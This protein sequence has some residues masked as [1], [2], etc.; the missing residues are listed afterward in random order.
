MTDARDA[1]GG[2]RTSENGRDASDCRERVIA[3]GV[4]LLLFGLISAFGVGLGVPN[5]YWLQVGEMQAFEGPEGVV[6]FV[7]VDRTVRLPG[8]LRSAPVRKRP[9][10][11]LRIDVSPTGQVTRNTLRFNNWTT[12]NMNIAPIVRLEDDFYLVQEPSVGHP[13]CLL[14]RVH[15]KDVV[16]LSLAESRALLVSA[17]LICGSLE[18]GELAPL[19]RVSSA[20]GWWRLNGASDSFRRDPEGYTSERHKLRIRF[21]EADLTESIVAESLSEND[22][23]ITPAVTVITRR[24]KSYRSLVY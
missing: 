18:L 9:L 12:F 23:W 6:L 3:G 21:T 7:E 13:D 1:I 2:Q 4:T 19:D 8:S 22:R 10:Q 5:T 15:G 11:L 20:N 24:W 17:R 14:H 16:P